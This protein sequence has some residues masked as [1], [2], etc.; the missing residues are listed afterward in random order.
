MIISWNR[1]SKVWHETWPILA[2]ANEQSSR[3]GRYQNQG[4]GATLYI[5]KG[6]SE[7]DEVIITRAAGECP[8][9]ALHSNTS[10]TITPI[11]QPNLTCWLSCFSSREGRQNA[12]SDNSSG[13][14]PTVQ[15]QYYHLD[16]TTRIR[17]SSSF[18]IRTKT[19]DTANANYKQQLQ[20]K[21]LG[22]WTA[23]CCRIAIQQ[24]SNLMPSLCRLVVRI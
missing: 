16:Y 6:V 18:Y 10:I 14:P 22:F 5:K 24:I 9:D 1:I 7:R 20:K 15:I 13:W 23:V 21:L 11:G 17:E 8:V 3:K 4:T 12:S 19:L 2:I